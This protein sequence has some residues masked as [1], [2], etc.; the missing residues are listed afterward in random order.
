[1]KRGSQMG[2]AISALLLMAAGVTNLCSAVA[3]EEAAKPAGGGS[4]VNTPPSLRS[5]AEEREARQQL[6]QWQKWRKQWQIQSRYEAHLPRY[7]RLQEDG[8]ESGDFA[9]FRNR[10]PELVPAI[11]APVPKVLDVRSNEGPRVTVVAENTPTHIV[12]EQLFQQAKVPYSIDPGVSG[13]MTLHITATPFKK[14]FHQVLCRAA[15]AVFFRQANGVYVIQ[16]GGDV[17]SAD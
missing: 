10:G 7:G 12:F 5:S 17:A 2:L 8:R 6:L 14:A 11:Y 1:M 13:R 4:S 9:V 16:R 15:P 3:H